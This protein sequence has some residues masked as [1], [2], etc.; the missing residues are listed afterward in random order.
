MKGQLFRDG[1]YFTQYHKS[2]Q[3]VEDG[4]LALTQGFLYTTSPSMV[5]C[6]YI[7]FLAYF[8]TTLLYRPGMEFKF[9]SLMRCFISKALPLGS[10]GGSPRSIHTSAMGWLLTL[11]VKSSNQATGFYITKTSY[12]SSG[13]KVYGTNVT[14]GKNKELNWMNSWEATKSRSKPINTQ[15]L[16]GQDGLPAQSH[17]T[18]TAFPSILH[19]S[20]PAPWILKPSNPYSFTSRFSMPDDR[21]F[22]WL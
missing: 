4:S 22:F 14:N 19:T 17:G 16:C 7:C 15:A 12:N 5:S 3:E 11:P 8:Y 9:I 18:L 1:K 20:S 13:R 10:W 6:N 21:N 2:N